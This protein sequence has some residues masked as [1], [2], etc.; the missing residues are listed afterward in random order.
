M[1]GVAEFDSRGMVKLA[2]RGRVECGVVDV[3]DSLY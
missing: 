1:L 3:L 2:A